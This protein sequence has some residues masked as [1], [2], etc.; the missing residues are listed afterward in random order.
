MI[1]QIVEDRDGDIVVIRRIP[2]Y[3]LEDARDRGNTV[4]PRIER[5][6]HG[7]LQWGRGHEQTDHTHSDAEVNR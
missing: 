1:H 2:R 3:E 5:Y 4:S 6:E 7:S